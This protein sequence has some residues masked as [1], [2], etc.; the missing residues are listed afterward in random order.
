MNFARAYKKLRD[1]LKKPP[2]SLHMH[3]NA[4]TTSVILEFSYND[5]RFGSWQHEYKEHRTKE[6]IW[7]RGDGQTPEARILRDAGLLE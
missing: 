2:S 5:L 6:P 1:Y 3:D 4:G 7:C